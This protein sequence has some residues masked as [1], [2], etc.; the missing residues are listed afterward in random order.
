ML[1]T[2]Y[3]RIVKCIIGRISQTSNVKIFSLD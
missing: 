2:N 3:S 1:F